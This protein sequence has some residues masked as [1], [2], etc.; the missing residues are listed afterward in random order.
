MAMDDGR[1]MDGKGGQAEL[2]YPGIYQSSIVNV[3]SLLACDIR[4]RQF[5]SIRHQTTPVSTQA[6]TL[7]SHCSRLR[8]G[9]DLP[10]PALP[11][12]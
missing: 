11:V 12:E 6:S 1:W 5:L 10:S 7:S 2:L 9:G 3:Y 4:Q 8:R